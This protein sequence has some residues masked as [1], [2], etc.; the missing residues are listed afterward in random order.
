MV[1]GMAEIGQRCDEPLHKKEE[2]RYTQDT[3]A[4]PGLG[5]VTHCRW[6]DCFWWTGRHLRQQDVFWSMWQCAEVIWHVWQLGGALEGPTFGFW[7]LYLP[8]KGERLPQRGLT[9]LFLL[10]LWHFLTVNV[11]NSVNLIVSLVNCSN[12]LNFNSKVMD[13]YK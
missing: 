6:D 7:M 8:K 9:S 1:A 4:E 3:L 5:G 13:W 2:G 10:I 11:K 12:D